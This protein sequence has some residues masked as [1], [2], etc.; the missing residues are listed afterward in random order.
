MR[1]YFGDVQNDSDNPDLEYVEW[2][3]FEMGDKILD[4]DN[5][6]PIGGI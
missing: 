2:K 6:E 1:V 5:L 4:E 3:D